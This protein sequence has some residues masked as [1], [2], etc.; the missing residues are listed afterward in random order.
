MK[1]HYHFEDEESVVVFAQVGR[2]ATGWSF[3]SLVLLFAAAFRWPA[4]P[5]RLVDFLAAELF[6][7]A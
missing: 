3:S 2:H 6:G 5:F 4:F 7:L 1:E